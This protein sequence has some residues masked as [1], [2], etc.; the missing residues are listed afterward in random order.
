MKFFVLFIAVLNIFVDSTPLDDYVNNFDSYYSY[1]IIQQYKL[2]NNEIYVINMT[3]QKWLDESLVDRPVWW[4]Y[5]TISIPNKVSRKDAALLW[6]GEGS[7]KDKVPTP[8]DYDISLVSNFS[9]STYTVAAIIQQ[10][11]NQPL[12]FKEDERG[13]KRSED[14]LIAWGWK[15]F[16]EN[17]AEP[18]FLLRFPMVKAVSKAMDTIQI[19]VKENYKIEIKKFMLAGKSKRGWTT[20]LNAALDSQRV[21]SAVPI[22]MDLLNLNT[23]LHQNFKAIGGW[24]FAFNDY[25]EVNI[26]Q[27][28]DSR[29]LFEMQKMIDPLCRIF[30]IRL[31]LFQC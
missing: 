8:T 11:P 30:F 21:F 9:L 15:K 28:I 14:A 20:W 29:E 16:I 7:N 10:I 27:Y 5:L 1:N 2:V 17:T 13:R 19:F 4:H 23:G 31:C 24:T 12:V 3:S 18:T 26:T 22:V 6:I 25:Y